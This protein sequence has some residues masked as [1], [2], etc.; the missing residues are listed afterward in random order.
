M[1]VAVIVPTLGGEEG[2]RRLAGAL[3]GERSHRLLI[4]DN[5][6]R[7]PPDLQLEHPDFEVIST[8]ENLGFGRAVNLGAERARA[9]V[10]L[11]TN[12]D[13]VPHPGFVEELAAP[14]ES[15]PERSVGAGVLLREVEPGLVD[16][17]G[18]Q[19]DRTLLPFDYMH[20][21]RADRIGA[22]TP[23]PFGPTGG[24]MSISRELFL[25]MGGFDERLFA[26]HEDIDLAV[27]LRLRGVRT[28]LCPHARAVHAHS[29]TLGSGSPKKNYLMGFGRGLMLRK[30]G[31]LSAR[32]L[33]GVIGRE[34]SICAGQAAVD[35]NVAGVRGR[36]RGYREAKRE[37]EYP[38]SLLAAA[39]GEAAMIARLRRRLKGSGS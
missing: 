11:V 12:D 20:G 26:Y 35:R 15:D 36:I 21:Q 18:V 6:A 29:T 25:A 34:I 3:A 24:A 5:A 22:L 16:S 27:R 8:P 2:L 32:R 37:H 13:C 39:G 10:L 4:V 30:W 17:A 23:A 38:G 1:D 9:E 31:V 28:V 33:P 19:V 14:V 7:L